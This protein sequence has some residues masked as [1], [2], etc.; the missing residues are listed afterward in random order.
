MKP[1]KKPDI[2]LVVIYFLSL[3]LFLLTFQQASA[4]DKSLLEYYGADHTEAEINITGYVVSEQN[5]PPTKAQVDPLIRLQ[6]RYALGLMRSRE[7]RAAALYPKWTFSILE[8]KKT[9]AGYTVK[10]NL[11]TKGVF[12]T[13]TT[14][15]TFTIPYN[16]KKIF[17]QSQNKCMN[18]TAQAENFWY[19][20]EPLIIGC[21]LKENTDYFNYT[22]VITPLANTSVTYPEYNKLLDASKTIKITM[23]FGFEHY[24]FQNWTPD[25]GE[26]WGIKG[27]KK[28]TDF[29]KRLGFSELIWNQQQI[30]ALYKTKDRFTPYVTEF[31]LAGQTANIRIRLI[32]ADTGFNYNSTAFHTI[33]KEAVAKESVIIYNG[34]SGI[35]HNLDLSAIEKHRGIKLTFNPNYQIL[36]LG[37]CVPYSYYT[38]MFFSRKKTSADPR[39]SLNLD[40]LSYGKESVFANN[41]DQALTRAL[42]KYAQQGEKQ[43]YQFIIKSSPNYFFGVNG[44][45]DNPT[46]K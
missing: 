7:H 31:N 26:D 36:F 29:L 25:G 24:G 6:M 10:Y 34:H 12:A 44:D 21:P 32:L 18:K 4:Y 1:D 35:G 11:K 39:G 3:L 33:F 22:T 28:Q 19:H 8:T 5:S 14:G 27:Y 40:I 23:F 13:G 15:Y 41:E 38:D 20:W 42:V 9:A 30:S 45:E 37:S 16:P 43:S 46:S 17:I 2:K